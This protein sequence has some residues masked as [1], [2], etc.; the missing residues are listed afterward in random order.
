[1]DE[2]GVLHPNGIVVSENQGV[3][4]LLIGPCSGS[5]PGILAVAIGGGGTTNGAVDPLTGVD[6]GSGSGYVEFM[7]MSPSSSFTTFEATVGLAEQAS[8]L[9]QGEQN[10]EL[11]ELILP[12]RGEFKRLL[13]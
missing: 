3:D 2:D 11:S 13:L 1:M 10:H 7:E 12:F 8:E 9:K 4:L 5:S 6:A